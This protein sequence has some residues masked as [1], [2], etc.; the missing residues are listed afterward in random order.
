MKEAGLEP[1][2]VPWYQS[3]LP[4]EGNQDKESSSEE[5]VVVAKKI[6]K[7]RIERATQ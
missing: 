6:K 2:M 4:D 3:D 5:E 1:E 7:K